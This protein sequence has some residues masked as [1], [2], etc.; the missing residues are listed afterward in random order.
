MEYGELERRMKARFG[1]KEAFTSKLHEVAHAVVRGEK[2]KEFHRDMGMLAYDNDIHLRTMPRKRNYRQ[3]VLTLAV[4][5]ELYDRLGVSIDTDDEIG[6]V[7][8]SFY[9]LTDDGCAMQ[10]NDVLVEVQRARALKCVGRWADRLAKWVETLSEE[11]EDDEA[12]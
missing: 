2:P 3:E 4:Q 9:D 7:A 6:F 1:E 11:N 10:S 8:E 12:A 5:E